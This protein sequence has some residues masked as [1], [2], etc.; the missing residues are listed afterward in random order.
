M[1]MTMKKLSC[2]IVSG[3][4]T[5]Q[6]APTPVHGS[7]LRFVIEMAAPNGSFTCGVNWDPSSETLAVELLTEALRQ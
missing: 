5:V 1:I 4:L 3:P 2:F 6:E 7:R